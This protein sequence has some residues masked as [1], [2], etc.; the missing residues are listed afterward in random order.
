MDE[1]PFDE[2]DGF[3]GIVGGLPLEV[4]EGFPS[5]S[6]PNSQI[7]VSASGDARYGSWAIGLEDDVRLLVRAF[8]AG[9]ASLCR[10]LTEGLLTTRSSG[11]SQP[12]G[13][14]EE[15]NV[16]L[17]ALGLD[18]GDEDEL[19]D[20]IRMLVGERMARVGAQP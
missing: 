7:Y 19:R 9:G 13:Q 8:A 6:S 3:D 11:Q 5:R 14:H 10:D 2:A 20:L 18:S 16:E 1:W 15:V 12:P 4:D 17:H